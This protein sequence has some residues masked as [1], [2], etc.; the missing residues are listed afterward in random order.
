MSRA[1]LGLAGI[2]AF[3]WGV[4]WAAPAGRAHF[5]THG[6]GSLEESLG[7]AAAA[8]SVGPN[9]LYYNAANLGS[10]PSAISAEFSE[11][12]PG[13]GYSW[14]GSSFDLGSGKM[15]LGLISLDL[16]EITSREGL[17]DPG[18]ETRNR[19]RA[20]LL[21]VSHK[22]SESLQGG[23]TL[24]ALD[25][26]L[27]GHSSGARFLD[28][29]FSSRWGSQWSIGAVVKNAYF[30]GLNFAGHREIYP[31]ELRAGAAASFGGL[32]I[33]AQAHRTLDGSKPGFSIG[34]GYSP[35]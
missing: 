17:L 4:S 26:Q 31:A 24:G 25:F 27:A 6:P 32:L 9:A 3:S 20:Y 23:L 35:A 2:L 5:L 30:S 10:G 1:Y 33:T 11:I 19:Q 8:A 16:G 34:L 15:G 7:G 21:G 29:G 28:A 12:F 14:L 18:R 13:V 22:L